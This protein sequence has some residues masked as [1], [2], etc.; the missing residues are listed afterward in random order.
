[1]NIVKGFYT[2]KHYPLYR[3]LVDGDEI[4]WVILRNAEK[5]FMVCLGISI[6]EGQTWI[7]HNSVS[8]RGWLWESYDTQVGRIGTEN[9]YRIQIR[10]IYIWKGLQKEQWN[11][12]QQS[13]WYVGENQ[14]CHRRWWVVARREEVL[15]GREDGDWVQRARE[16]VLSVLRPS[17]QDKGEP[18][19]SGSK[20]SH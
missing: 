16:L 18:L 3:M 6:K 8:E 12:R 2:S 10:T 9:A 15:W 19:A 7:I 4:N 20:A 5:R 11:I 1:M 14:Q 17:I 13:H